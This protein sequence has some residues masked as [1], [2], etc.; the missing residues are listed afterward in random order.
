MLYDV[1]G[2]LHTGTETGLTGTGFNV[3]LRRSSTR[4]K[5]YAHY[6]AGLNPT[7]CHV[8]HHA[9]WIWIEAVWRQGVW[10]GC[11]SKVLCGEPHYFIQLQGV[12]IC[13]L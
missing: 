12:F 11:R 10:I 2:A 6:T 4:H 1:I 8:A 7:H 9:A 3:V 13:L 5:D